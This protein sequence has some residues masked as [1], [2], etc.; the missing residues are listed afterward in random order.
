M[1]HTLVRLLIALAMVVGLAS[2]GRTAID[3]REFA[4]AGERQ[5][6]ETLTSTLRC[7]KCQNQSLAESTAPIAR[8]LRGEIY[9]MLEAGYSNQQIVDFLVARYGDFVRYDPALTWGTALLWFGPLALLLA[10]GG[11]IALI[12]RRRRGSRPTVEHGLSDQERHRLA[13]ILRGVEPSIR[14]EP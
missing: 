5:R 9:R 6:Y 8:D 2:Q 7:P 12:V 13:G 4:N 1:K 14:H 10:G 3:A 11:A